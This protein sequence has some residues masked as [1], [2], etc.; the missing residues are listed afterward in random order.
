MMKPPSLSPLDASMKIAY[1]FMKL[2]NG[3]HAMANLQI[4]GIDDRIHEELK[5]LAA[6]ENRSLS[7]QVLFLIRRFISRRQAF[8][9]CKSGAEALLELSGSWQD[10]RQADDIVS[11]IRKGRKNSDKLGEGL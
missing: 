6:M 7:Q 8:E 1:L 3:R 2:I 5:A 10:S 4:K 9:S 11:D